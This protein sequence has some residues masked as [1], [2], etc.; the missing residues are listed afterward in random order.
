MAQG[1]MAQIGGLTSAPIAR[2]APVV[3][4]DVRMVRRASRN[5]GRWTPARL[6]TATKISIDE[7]MPMSMPRQSP[8]EMMPDSFILKEHC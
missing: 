6:S 3:A 2:S 7:I 5:L 8:P 1:I 4:E